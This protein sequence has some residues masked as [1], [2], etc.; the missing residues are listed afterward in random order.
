M[1]VIGVMVN[2]FIGDVQVNYWCFVEVGVLGVGLYKIF[3]DIVV[4]FVKVFWYVEVILV[5]IM[6]QKQYVKIVILYIGGEVIVDDIG[7]MFF[8]FFIDNM[9]LQDFNYWEVGVI[10]SNIY[11][12][13]NNIQFYCIVIVMGI[14]L[15]GQVIKMVIYYD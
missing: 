15:V 11:F 5:F 12:D 10:L 1:F 9:C 3:K 6:F 13:R 2:I 8:V 4:Q 7:M 14:I